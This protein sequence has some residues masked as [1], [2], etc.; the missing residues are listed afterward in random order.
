MADRKKVDISELYDCI[1]ERKGCYLVLGDIKSLIPINEISLKAGDLAIITSMKR[2]E[3]AAGQ[4][5]I[6]FRIGG[7]E[8][9]VLTNSTDEGY[10]KSIGVEIL[11]HNEEHISWEGK[12]IPLSMFVKVDNASPIEFS[13]EELKDIRTRL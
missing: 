4:E 3:N 7:D 2:M 9:V 12:E 1:K 8:F 6:V 5:D 13:I 11:S 10:A